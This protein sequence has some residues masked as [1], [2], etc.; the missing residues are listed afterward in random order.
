MA[1]LDISRD[2]K[3]LTIGAVCRILQEE[4]DDVS[5]SKIR[6]LEDQNLVTP[7]R[8][9]GGYRLYGPD[10]VDRLRSILRLQRDEFLPLRVIRQELQNGP[11]DR[12]ERPQ[13]RRTAGL[14][15]DRQRFTRDDLIAA[16]GADE[17]FVR[18]LEDF[19]LIAPSGPDR[20]YGES[21][22]DVVRIALQ[23][24]GY[25]LGPRHLKQF[26]TAVVRAAGLIDGVV[27]PA[28]RSRNADRRDAGLDDLATLARLAADLTE[29]ILVREVHGAATG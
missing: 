4:F 3:P 12:S 15:E 14:V 21:E 28:L 18:E 8:T 27:A 24:A 11:S 25:G 29:R 26:H 6:F 2:G 10:E 16:T 5:I 7:R 22:T 13:R 20:D 1:K 23:M 17:A 9:P 19:G